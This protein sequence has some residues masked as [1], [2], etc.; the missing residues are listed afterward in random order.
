MRNY[1]TRILI[2]ILLFLT[3][4]FASGYF[5]QP[6]DYDNS[7]TRLM[8][9]SAMVD[10]HTYA[11]DHLQRLPHFQT[12]DVSING[13]HQYSNKAPGAAM[14]G[15]PAYWLIKKIFPARDKPVLF[16]WHRHLIN[17]LTNSLLF[18][19][20]GLVLFHVGLRWTDDVFCA[21]PGVLAFAFGSI[22]WSHSQYFSGHLMTGILFFFGFTCLMR[23]RRTS[24]EKDASFTSLLA[25]SGGL[26]T[27]FGFACEYT[28]LFIV[29]VLFGYL[30]W[31][32]PPFSR[33]VFFSFGAAIPLM[34]VLAYNFQCFGSFFSTGYHHL[35]LDEFAEGTAKGFLGISFPQPRSLIMLLF[36]P[37]RG[38]FFLMPVY[39][40]SLIGLWRMWRSARFRPE[41]VVISSIALWY[42]FLISGYF[43]WHGGWTYGPRYLV[44]TLPFLTLALFF[45]PV[46]SRAWGLLLVLSILLVLPGIIIMPHTPPVFKNPIFELMIP[47]MKMGYLPDT[48]LSAIGFGRSTG[49]LIG[50]AVIVLAIV[51]LLVLGYR[52]RSSAPAYATGNNSQKILAIFVTA[53][54]IIGLLVTRSPEQERTLFNLYR[55]KLYGTYHWTIKNFK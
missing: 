25:F 19:I 55:Q 21:L 46:R 28:S 5:H 50:L 11:I 44:P 18:A 49:V 23:L 35:A 39:F 43:G 32:R 34:F 13:G 27:G 41:M 29:I 53:A 30:F 3:L 12:I 17:L 24:D 1:T 2:N 15:A 6:V 52:I 31:L 40:F 38:F 54:I 42:F 37:S 33:I 7:R 22:A 45:S 9:I 8:L 47:L 26:F 36:S 16:F 4:F 10:H 20:A 51:L 48:I 14:I